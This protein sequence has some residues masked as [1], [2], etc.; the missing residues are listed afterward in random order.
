MIGDVKNWNLYS[1]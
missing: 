1:R